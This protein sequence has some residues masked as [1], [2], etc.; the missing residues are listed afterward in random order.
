MMEFVTKHGHEVSY[1][2]LGIGALL[3]AGGF[4]T[5]LTIGLPRKGTPLAVVG[6]V[7]VGLG[8]LGNQMRVDAIESR[9]ETNSGH[10]VN[11]PY[12]ASLDIQRTWVV[13]GVE[14]KCTLIH[15]LTRRPALLCRERGHEND[16]TWAQEVVG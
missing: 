11:G 9:I 8:M 5:A 3:L 10:V 12:A 6:V 13:D 4:F 7:L 16:P 14:R 1:A 2:I 15:D